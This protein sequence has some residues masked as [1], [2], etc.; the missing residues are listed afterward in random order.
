MAV[1]L[2]NARAFPSHVVRVTRDASKWSMDTEP[3]ENSDMGKISF[4]QS[5]ETTSKDVNLHAFSHI[6]PDQSRI[7]KTAQLVQQNNRGVLNQVAVE[8]RD[9]A[10]P[11]VKPF[12]KSFFSPEKLPDAPKSVSSIISKF[13]PTNENEFAI[14]VSSNF[15]GQN[16]FSGVQ[17]EIATLHDTTNPTNDNPFN[18]LDI[19]NTDQKDGLISVPTA[20]TQDQY[21]QTS[22][23]AVDFNYLSSQMSLTADLASGTSDSNFNEGTGTSAFNSLYA[24]GNMPNTNTDA[25]IS[26]DTTLS[27]T[28]LD[29]LATTGV[30]DVQ[31]SVTNTVD[32]N[33]N[34]FGIKGAVSETSNTNRIN[35]SSIGNGSK[36]S[37]MNTADTNSETQ[38]M[39][40]LEGLNFSDLGISTGNVDF[41]ADQYPTTKPAVTT[42]ATNEQI[43][44]ME[45]RSKGT[46]NLRRSTLMTVSSEFIPK[47]SKTSGTEAN[48]TGNTLNTNSRKSMMV[49][50][51]PFE[52]H[53]KGPF[54]RVRTP[55][56][57]LSNKETDDNKEPVGAISNNEE[58]TTR[59]TITTLDSVNVSPSPLDKTQTV[60]ESV[61]SEN[62]RGIG[63]VVSGTQVPQTLDN[64]LSAPG[65][66]PDNANLKVDLIYPSAPF[67]TNGQV[68]DPFGN[69][70]S[71]NN[72][73]APVTKPPL[74]GNNKG[75][76]VE[77]SIK[78]NSVPVNDN[79]V[80]PVNN[81]NNENMGKIKLEA[82]QI[83]SNPVKVNNDLRDV[84]K[85][86]IPHRHAVSSDPK[87]L[88]GKGTGD[89]FITE[90]DV[91]ILLP[92]GINNGNSVSSMQANG[93][94]TTGQSSPS[95]NTS[96]N[97]NNNAINISDIKTNDE[98]NSVV[99]NNPIVQIG[100]TRPGNNPQGNTINAGARANNNNDKVNFGLVSTNLPNQQAID[101]LNN[102]DNSKDGFVSGPNDDERISKAVGRDLQENISPRKD[103]QGQVIN[104]IQNT[105]GSVNKD[106]QG[107][108]QNDQVNPINTPPV[109]AENMNN[110]N[111]QNQNQEINNNMK[112]SLPNQQNNAGIISGVNGNSSWIASVQNNQAQDNMMANMNQPQGFVSKDTASLQQNN[113]PVNA[114]NSQ[115][116]LIN[117]NP[118]NAL[119]NNPINSRTTQGANNGMVMS[120]SN[121]NNQNNL[122]NVNGFTNNQGNVPGMIN[123]Q[124]ISNNQVQN[125]MPSTSFGSFQNQNA[126]QMNGQLQNIDNVAT[127]QVVGQQQQTANGQLPSPSAKNIGDQNNQANTQF[128]QNTISQTG[129]S[130]PI[131]RGQMLQN[132][133]SGNQNQF[134]N[135]FNGQM[136]GNV[137]HVGQSRGVLNGQGQNNEQMTGNF[138]NQLQN[139]FGNQIN[140]QLQNQPFVGNFPQTLQNQNG[141]QINGQTQNNWPLRGTINNGL[142]NQGG[143]KINGQMAGNVP[144]AFPNQFGIHNT[145]FANQGPMGN[146]FVGNGQGNT[147]NLGSITPGQQIQQNGGG[148]VVP[149]AQANGLNNFQNNQ[150][151]PLNGQNINVGSSQFPLQTG[152]NNVL[153]TMGSENPARMGQFNLDVRNPLSASQPT[154]ILQQQVNTWPNVQG[155]FPTND[156]FSNAQ[157]SWMQGGQASRF[158]L[159]GPFVNSPWAN[160]GPQVMID[161][162]FLSPFQGLQG[163]QPVVIPFK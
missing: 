113:I 134:A 21:P 32:N 93:Q 89:R 6:M 151:T 76:F 141:D 5:G 30:T 149:N 100:D 88:L 127:G 59:F 130:I 146:D 158:P 47:Q 29:Y 119:Q 39:G 20:A 36:T 132:G 64:T 79:N 154:G 108:F 61:Q 74:L 65:S 90:P 157:M 62:N 78:T 60:K 116:Q 159:N 50:A 49:V 104:S 70:G 26:S 51:K 109:N 87:S 98:L 77:K 42:S 122:Q 131:N 136:S 54:L 4:F 84:V 83:P 22:K 161:N 18:M 140:G 13:K 73:K 63:I 148:K 156:M 142:Q 53:S 128:M 37:I 152:P 126:G 24:F 27:G 9:R 35:K 153:N 91:Q 41:P 123:N 163:P 162:S 80:L 121:Q 155:S 23:T 144:N 137:Q 110:V 143:N 133:L 96:M 138:Q 52:D 147:P 160:M 48:S 10:T 44:N 7:S 14:P 55:F 25:A 95:S 72:V 139:Q 40:A 124:M 82:T 57:D 92:G 69:V 129:S 56:M 16:P 75:R 17:T 67:P 117:N 45:N 86:D 94:R 46:N 106:M 120:Q 99:S 34:D 2:S 19:G 145:L 66:I 81:G 8:N 31:T 115:V 3:S 102:I 71:Q 43:W 12:Q 107:A 114:W 11:K 68:T 150:F 103:L 15:I 135:A 85:A 125:G 38:N 105:R 111:N 33:L 101:G 112:T 118:M 1:G 58:K 97:M 28:N